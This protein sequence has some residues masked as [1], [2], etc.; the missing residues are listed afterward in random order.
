[1]IV[2]RL[3]WT[4]ALRRRRL[5]A[6]NFLVPV[7]L[8][9]PV[10]LAPTAAPHRAAV[11][12][13]FFVFFGTF[14]ACVPLLRDASAGWLDTLLGTGVSPRRW[15]AERALAE[16]S[17]DAIQLAPP[18]LVLLA[19][20]GGAAAAGLELLAALC[21]AL[22]AADLLGL[23]VAAVVRSLAEGVLACAATAL[24]A[25]H[26]AGVFR[27]PPGEGF[28][29]SLA[30]WSPFRPLH[31]TLRTVATGAAPA[32]GATWG[33]PVASVVLFAATVLLVAPTASR[34]LRWPHA[35]AD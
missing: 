35:T 12:A 11:F 18:A 3:R 9:A 6:W 31:E 29:A 32:E 19:A 13:V 4:L 21:L 1:M 27:P 15:L 14:G 34:R 22:F 25:L 17:L 7:G 33:L 26:A 30:A 20:G 10:A 24:L 8:L 2:W 28:G 23:L 5:L 16:T